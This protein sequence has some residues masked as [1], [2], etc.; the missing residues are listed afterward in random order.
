MSEPKIRTKTFVAP[1]AGGSVNGR[2]FRRDQGIERL[3]VPTPGGG[4]HEYVLAKLDDGS[5][6]GATVWRYVDPRSKL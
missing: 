5:V 2:L 4:A 6:D 3:L 1:A